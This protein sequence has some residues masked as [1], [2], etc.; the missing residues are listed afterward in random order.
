MTASFAGLTDADA[1]E[2]EPPDLAV[3]AGPGFVVQMVNVAERIWR[4]STTGAPQ[5]ALTQPLS[6]LYHS[7]GDQLTDPRL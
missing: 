6:S 5:V 7:G 2:F 1:G 4:T 3:A